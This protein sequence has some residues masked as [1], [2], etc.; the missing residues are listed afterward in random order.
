MQ[1][2]QTI[3]KIF[4]RLVVPVFVTYD[5]PGHR[6]ITTASVP[7]YLDALQDEATRAAEY[8]RARIDA[9]TRPADGR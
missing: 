5:S 8:L 6:G 4:T 3:E 9:A 2:N 7:S 1:P